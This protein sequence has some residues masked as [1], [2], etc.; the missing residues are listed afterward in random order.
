VEVASLN[1]EH[2]G[3]A[4]VVNH[5]SKA[6][7]VKVSSSR[8]LHSLRWITPEGPRPLKIQDGAW[9]MEVGAFDGAVVEWK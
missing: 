7:K 8:P 5:G 3:Y 1:A 6:A 2:S 9:E 4:V